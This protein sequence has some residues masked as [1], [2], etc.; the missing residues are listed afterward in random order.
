MLYKKFEKS[1]RDAR[2]PIAFPVQ[3]H[4]FDT[5]SECD[6]WTDRRRDRQTPRR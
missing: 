3:L 4:C 2:K 6:G 5:I 1:S